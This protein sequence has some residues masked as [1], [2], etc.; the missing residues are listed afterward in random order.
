MSLLSCLSRW[1]KDMTCDI[2]SLRLYWFRRRYVNKCAESTIKTHIVS[3]QRGQTWSKVLGTES[4]LALALAR[5]FTSD[6]S[7]VPLAAWKTIDCSLPN[8]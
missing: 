1:G 5:R 4:T 2:T 3:V 6:P 8:S 7:C